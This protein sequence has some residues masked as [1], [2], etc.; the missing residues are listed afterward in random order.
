MLN[1]TSIYKTK[2]LTIGFLIALFTLALLGVFAYTLIRVTLY[3]QTSDALEI[4]LSGRQRMLSQKLTKEVLLLAQSQNLEMKKQHRQLL[5]ATIAGWT[6]VHNGLQYGDKEL[7]LLGNNSQKV[8]DLFA[9]IEPHYQ[10]IKKAVDSILKLN[11]IN[12]TQLS[13][14]SPMVQ[15]IVKASPLYLRWMD[16]T[17][18]QFNMIKRLRNGLIFSN[19]LKHIS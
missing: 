13:P 10:A 3:R 17:V 12:L 11:S 5:S 6:Q 8:Q 9:K 1:N 16:R 15:D 2:N 7:K 4:N 18:F 19:A 14:N